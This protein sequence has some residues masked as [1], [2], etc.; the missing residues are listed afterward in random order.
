M[1]IFVAGMLCVVCREP[2]QTADECVIFPP[3]VANRNDPLVV[4]HDGVVH[5]ACLQDH[6]LGGDA[7]RRSNEVVERGAPAARQCAVCLDVI[8]NPDDYF[9]TGY[10]A[11]PGSDPVAEFNYLHLHLS[12]FLRWD[13]AEEFR[14]CVEAFI[15]SP[16]WDGSQVIFDPLPRWVRAD[17]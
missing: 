8:T 7:V 6:P 2:I 14:H 13:R 11:D 17:P 9:G 1:A 12:H 3:F 10:L 5:R 16:H 15:S 4:F